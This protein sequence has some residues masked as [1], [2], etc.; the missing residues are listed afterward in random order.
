MLCRRYG[1]RPYQ[2][3][4]QLRTPSRHRAPIDRSFSVKQLQLI[5]VDLLRS[6]AEQR[7]TG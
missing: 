3:H 5:G 6:A 4:R 1:L 7:P 2:H